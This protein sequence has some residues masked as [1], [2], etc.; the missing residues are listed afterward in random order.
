MPVEVVTHN[1]TGT[2]CIDFRSDTCVHESIVRRNARD[3]V[4]MQTTHTN[5][6]E[7]IATVH[8]KYAA[9]A[10]YNDILLAPSGKAHRC[11]HMITN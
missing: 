1:I 7:M 11:R 5:Q 2:P 6:T 3:I 8:V 4:R 9:N 10:C